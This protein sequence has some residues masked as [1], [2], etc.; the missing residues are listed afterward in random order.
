MLPKTLPYE[1]MEMIRD[2]IVEGTY[3][4]GDRLGEQDLEARFSSS[5]SPIRE[6]LRLLEMQGLVTHIPRRGF[7]VREMSMREI[8]DLYDLRADL[9]GTSVKILEGIGD[10][11]GLVETLR[12]SNAKMRQ[13]MENNDVKGH[14]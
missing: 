9:E 10:L 1:M 3:L 2:L 8:R 13:A 6:A 4:P 11:S 5:R 7:R 12:A 14:L